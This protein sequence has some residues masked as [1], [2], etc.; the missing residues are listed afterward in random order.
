MNACNFSRFKTRPARFALIRIL[1]IP[2]IFL[3]ALRAQ[4]VQT[5]LLDRPGLQVIVSDGVEMNKNSSAGINGQALHLDF[6]FKSGAGYGGIRL[7]LPLELPENYRFTFYLKARS[8]KQNLEF[9]LVD[10]SGD[11]VWW[12]NQRNF[13][14]SGEWQKIIIKKRDIEFAWGPI[15]DKTLRRIAFIEI[16]IASVEG[17]SGYLTLDELIFEALPPVLTGPVT[18]LVTSSAPGSNPDGLFDGDRNSGWRTTANQTQTIQFDLQAQRETG[19]LI[20][21]W[22]L[23][24]F[25]R[26]YTLS[27]SADGK[28]WEEVYHAEMSSGGRR[29]LRLNGLE[30][31]YL[32]LNMNNSNRNRGFALSEAQ[33]MD[34]NFA[35][36]TEQL[37]FEMAKDRPRGWLP[38]YF[39][40]EM[41]YWTI[42][43]AENDDLEILINEEGQVETGK[44]S[45]SIEPFIFAEGRL[46][47]WNETEHHQSLA[48]DYLPL[49]VVHRVAD[50]LGLEIKPF[51]IKEQTSATTGISRLFIRYRLSN[52]SAQVKSGRLYLALRPFQVNSPWQFL[53]TPGGVAPVRTIRADETGLFVNGT[54]LVQPVTGQSWF[55]GVAGF[56]DGGIL[57]YLSENILP[58]SVTITDPTSLASAAIAFDFYL[59][60]GA[61]QT[62][63]LQISNLPE[64]ALTPEQIEEQLQKVT[65]NWAEKLSAIRI[66]APD[67]LKKIV[68][69]LRSNL[70]YILINRDGFGIQPGSRSYERSWIRDGSLTASALLRFGFVK[71]AGQFIDW[72]ARNQFENGKVPC[73]VDRRGP[74]P[75][76]ENDSHGQLIFAIRQ[77]FQFTGDTLFLRYHFEHVRK[78]LNYMEELSA[79]RRTATYR[80]GTATE[81]ACYGLL[82]ESISHEGYSAKPMHSYWDDFFALRGY[83]DAVEIAGILG[84][85]EEAVQWSAARDRFRSDLYS[86]IRAALKLHQISYL[87]GCVEL[88]DFD[89]TS[90]ASALFPAGQ[91][92]SLPQEEL[93]YTFDR[94]FKYFSDRKNQSFNWV[95]YTPYEVRTIGAF[96]LLGQPDRAWQLWKFF[97]TDQRPSGW[98]HWAEV[99][100][101]GY[102][103]TG[104][105]GDM[106]HTWVGSDFIN[107]VRMMFVYEDEQAN[108]LQVGEGV[109]R[110][111]FNPGDSLLIGGLPTWYGNLSL[112]IKREG[113]S[114]LYE[115]QGNFRAELIRLRI[116]AG[117]KPSAATRFSISPDQQYIL[118]SARDFEG[119]CNVE[120][121]P[122]E[123]Y[124]P[125]QKGKP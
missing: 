2:L 53:N 48:G 80:N 83:N 67:S 63:Y 69:V 30:A 105:I 103:T 38:R 16:F 26:N 104:F 125:K 114:F 120:F 7:P 42:S 85:N 45:F 49:P 93:T 58:P 27:A 3:S 62:V 68:D 118:L 74:D 123:I 19:G 22:D 36:S 102:R 43:G 73:V 34:F 112:K 32:K 101:K 97:E 57:P 65:R 119:G 14:F 47:T 52:E 50:G 72:Y 12:R 116:P 23:L 61:S 11:N 70:G 122:A 41:S 91:K 84:R 13:E 107:S 1:T 4:P 109:L 88:G 86:S 108:A 37:F 89:A 124:K 75:V 20:L 55:S 76:P 64:K 110:Q 56:D 100:R 96:I 92:D 17:G 51:V 21:D 77:Y 71:E 82:P 8:G 35:R 60:P 90:T 33:I 95:D 28:T 117:L 111:W 106:P 40:N 9:K 66:E 94:Y 113:N 46:L 81:Q 29:Y 79:S 15:A 25:P 18:P 39:Y 24:D 98:N 6:N 44:S 115:I 54:T 10:A 5:D 99:V 59:Q 121:V 78:A 31:R 87:P